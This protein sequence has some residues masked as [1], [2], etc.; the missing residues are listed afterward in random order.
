LLGLYE[1]YEFSINNGDWG[2]D[3]LIYIYNKFDNKN[4][5]LI[6]HPAIEANPTHDMGRHS[7]WT[8]NFQFSQT[9]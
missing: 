2:T 1:R 3:S 8:M 6:Y 7:I 9:G 5:L 4:A